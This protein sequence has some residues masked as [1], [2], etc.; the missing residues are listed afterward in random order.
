MYKVAHVLARRPVT[1]TNGRGELVHD[2]AVAHRDVVAGS[3]HPSPSLDTGRVPAATVVGDPRRPAADV[4][5]REG[6]EIRA[7]RA[8]PPRLVGTEGCL[9]RRERRNR[10]VVLPAGR[11]S[12]ER[13][14]G[15]EGRGRWWA[16]EE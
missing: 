7:E 12:E 16:A 4:E 1:A 11:R 9:V 2:P 6:M 14:V 10:D 3:S 8:D 13:R 15:K 5:L